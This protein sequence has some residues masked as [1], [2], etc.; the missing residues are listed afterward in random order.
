MPPLI[1]DR[2]QAKE[3]TFNRDHHKCVHCGDP[4][5]DA[6]HLIDRALWEDGGYYLD[7]LV[8]LCS[9]CHWKAE[10]TEF[11]PHQLREEAGI[12]RTILPPHLPSAFEEQ[13]DKWGN[14]YLDKSSP[15]RVAGEMIAQNN[16][17]KVMRLG[18]QLEHISHNSLKYPR[19][20]HLPWSKGLQ[21]DDRRAPTLSFL[22]NEEIV[23]TEKMDGENTTLTSEKVYARSPDSAYH[24]S[25]AWIRQNHGI[26]AHDL[27]LGWR[28]C[29][30]NMYAKH[31]IVYD[32]LPSFF[33]LF[34]IWN[35]ANYAV[36][37]DDT[38]EWAGMLGMSHA[39]VLYRGPWDE[40]ILRDLAAD[41]ELKSESTEGYVVRAS[42][43]FPFTHFTH[44]CAK[45]VRANHVQ[46]S[47]FWRHEEVVPNLLAQDSE[48][49]FLP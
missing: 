17:Q 7:N 47:K 42:R 11:P 32:E 48:P 19:T 15:R 21:N 26:I 14:L 34:N 30:E 45:Y 5:V 9:D 25:R 33:M 40:K 1:A 49:N 41:L 31:S 43:A 23:V 10:T 4:A 18:N 44:L 36:S 3:L 24:E 13:Y 22:E 8:S 39:P 46:S 2:A 37:W 16:V 27:P 28:F 35:A 20:Y 29:G 6:H 12:K 38:V